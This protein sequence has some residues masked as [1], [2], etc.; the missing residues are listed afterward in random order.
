LAFIGEDDVTR[1]PALLS[2]TVTTPGSALNRV[3]GGELGIAAA[4]EQR[5]ADKVAKGGLVRVHKLHAFHLRE[6]A[7]V[8]RLDR[9]I[10][11]GR[12]GA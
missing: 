10:V 2:R 11:P 9:L 6:I 5:P 8:R 7:H 12:H 3:Q 1:L 4:S